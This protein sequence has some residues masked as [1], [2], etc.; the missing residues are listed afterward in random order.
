MRSQCKNCSKGG[1]KTA[2]CKSKPKSRRFWLGHFRYNLVNI[3]F[4]SNSCHV[5]CYLS[6]TN[7]HTPS[8]NPEI[9]QPIYYTHLDDTFC[10]P[11]Q[12]IETNNLISNWIC[13]G[14]YQES[15]ENHCRREGKWIAKLLPFLLQCQV[16][17]RRDTLKIHGEKTFLG[18]ETA[19]FFAR[20][21]PKMIYV[22]RKY[23]KISNSKE[24]H[25][26]RYFFLCQKHA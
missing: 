11:S 2:I 3:A 12:M 18:V 14:V 25:T 8:C 20:T 17:Q 4:D 10:S 6:R 22:F 19:F 21:S 5:F 15:I 1:H 23:M 9:V 7:Q 26:A 24:S 13:S 16:S